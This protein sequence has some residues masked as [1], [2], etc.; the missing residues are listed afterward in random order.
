MRILFHTVRT[1]FISSTA[2]SERHRY[3]SFINISTS[4]EVEL[5]FAMNFL[6]LK[7]TSSFAFV[8]LYEPFS[9]NHH[10]GPN[11]FLSGCI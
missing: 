6:E 5:A 9:Q 8:I 4:A 10:Q 3:I 1:M 7:A 11:Q 2:Q